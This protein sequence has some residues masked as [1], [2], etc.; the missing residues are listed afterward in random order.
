MDCVYMHTVKPPRGFFSSLC[1]LT[2]FIAL[3]ECVHATEFSCNR[4]C[5]LPFFLCYFC[6][7]CCCWY[8][9]YIFLSYF[10]SS[11]SSYFTVHSV[12]FSLLS[13]FVTC[14]K[15]PHTYTLLWLTDWLTT[16]EYSV[17]YSVRYS[18]YLL[19]FDVHK[20]LSTFCIQI[21]AMKFVQNPYSQ[22]IFLLSVFLLNLTKFAI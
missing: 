3:R 5:C 15:S 2:F 18:N 19:N 21:D 4:C 22:L 7:C 17:V 14:L 20:R 1:S 11:S 16:D 13:Q 8:S 9:F 10:F 12:Q 6:C